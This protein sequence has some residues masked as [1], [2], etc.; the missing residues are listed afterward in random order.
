M[1]IPSRF[2]VSIKPESL[3]SRLNKITFKPGSTVRL[4]V[5]G[6]KGDRALIDFG[7]FRATADMQVP[8]TLGAEL[9]AKVLE[10]GAQLK[11]VVIKVEPKDTASSDQRLNRL[12]GRTA[13]DFRKIST[14]LRQILNQTLEVHGGRAIPLA[15]RNILNSIHAYFEPFELREII[16]KLIPRIQA[17]VENSGIFFEK[18]LADVISTVLED[19]EAASKQKIDKLPEVRSV[20][21]RDL[22]SNLIML[23]HLSE[24][25]E[26][27]TKFFSPKVLAALRGIID[28][29]LNDITQ[30]QGRA[31]KHMDAGEP[32]QIFTFDLPL[33]EGTQAATLKIFYEKK[34]RTGSKKRFQISLLLSMDRLGEIRTDF[35][36]IE[37]DLVIT[38]FV[39]EPSTK[40]KIEENYMQLQEL[41]NSFFDQIQFNVM[42]SKKKV[43][44]F[45]RKNVLIASDKKVD[46]RI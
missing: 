31:V 24:D 46:L 40:V 25:K 43:M 42:V 23:Q 33:K 2:T 18:T 21:A 36:L 9:Q 5:I 35:F 30:Q 32:T 10:S 27:L 28:T 45:K 6:L 8:V 17:S 14:D 3:K 44:D 34:R 29:L 1:D 16:T 41:L 12:G 39:K 15:I 37:N 7:A 11:L 13:E 19:P 38:F 4:K 22:K 26:V 20:L